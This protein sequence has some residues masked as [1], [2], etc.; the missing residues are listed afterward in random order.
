MDTEI[1]MN[2]VDNASLL[3]EVKVFKETGCRSEELGRMILLIASKYSDK[4]SFA[5]YT[6]KDDMVCEAVLTCI[7][8]MH[9]CSIEEGSNLFAYFSKIIH[10]AF[11]NF[12]AK[13]KKHSN[14]KDVCYK[15]LD[16]LVEDSCYDSGS[17]AQYFNVS[18]IDY[19]VIRGKKKKKRRKRKK[20]VETKVKTGD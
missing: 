10:N 12:I 15:N 13:Q 16:F 4:G 20:K 2:Y 7:K 3:K 17:P 11:L 14:I 18:A 19:Q 9:N 8:Y 1:E 5:G 6:Y